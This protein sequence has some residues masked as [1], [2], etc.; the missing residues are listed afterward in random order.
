MFVYGVTDPV[1]SGVVSDGV[2]EGVYTD[3]FEVFVGSVLSN[4]IGVQYS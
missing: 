4:P 1:D 2:V 3:Y